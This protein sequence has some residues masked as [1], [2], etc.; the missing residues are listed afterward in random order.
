MAKDAIFARINALAMLM[1]LV[2]VPGAL[3]SQADVVVRACVEAATLVRTGIEL[4]D[5]LYAGMD[6]KGYLLDA[7]RALWAKN[8]ANN[9]LCAL[10]LELAERRPEAFATVAQNTRDDVRAAAAQTPVIP[11][12]GAGKHYG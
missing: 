3:E 12:F 4:S 6:P 2:Q 11:S 1:V 8:M 9:K 7:Y 5:A 10:V